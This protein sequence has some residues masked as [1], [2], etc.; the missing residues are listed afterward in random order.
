MLLSKQTLLSDQQAVTASAASTNIIDLGAAGTPVR[1]N[2][3]VRDIGAG[4]PVGI[5]IQ[6]TEAFTAAGAATLTVTLEVDDNDAF[7]SATTVWTSGAIGKAT[8]VAGYRLPIEYLPKGVNERYLRAYYTVATGPMTAGKI[9][10]GLMIDG[11]DS[12][13]R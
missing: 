7:G 9:T 4:Q 3:L 1:G 2:A 12:N 5:L 8:L 6:A 11:Q 13:I 10:C